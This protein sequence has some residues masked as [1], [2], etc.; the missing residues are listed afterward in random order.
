MVID[1]PYSEQKNEVAKGEI[2]PPSETPQEALEAGPLLRKRLHLA[3][4]NVAEILR[5]LASLDDTL[6]KSLNATR[7]QNMNATIR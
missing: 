1:D 4:P 6:M 7:A 3:P 5:N 2:L